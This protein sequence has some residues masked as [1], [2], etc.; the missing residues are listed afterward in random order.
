MF[1]ARKHDGRNCKDVVASLCYLEEK[2][3]EDIKREFYILR[4]SLEIEDMARNRRKFE[5]IMSTK[6]V[7]KESLRV[8]FD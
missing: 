3:G 1:Q 6:S 5:V 7:P 2:K 8:E 4:F